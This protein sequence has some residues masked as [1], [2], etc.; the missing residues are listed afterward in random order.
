MHSPEWPAG[1]RLSEARPIEAYLR[2]L[3]SLEFTPE[4]KSAHAAIRESG[5]CSD[6]QLIDIWRQ[7]LPPP[8]TVE[9][10][11]TPL[12]FPVT[13]IRRIEFPTEKRAEAVL[14]L[15]EQYG[16]RPFLEGVIYQCIRSK[17]KGA[18][19]YYARRFVKQLAR[20]GHGNCAQVLQS[21]VKRR[22]LKGMTID[23]EKE[24]KWICPR[25][26]LFRMIR[27]PALTIEFD[28]LSEFVNWN[29]REDSWVSWFDT[30]LLKEG[31]AE[32][33]HYRESEN[34]IRSIKSG[35]RSKV[36]WGK[37]LTRFST[38]LV[39]MHQIAAIRFLV[40]E[41]SDSF[42]YLREL[43]SSWNAFL[44]SRDVQWPYIVASIEDRRVIRL[45]IWNRHK[46]V[47][48]FEMDALYDK[49]PSDI[50]AVLR[51]FNRIQIKERERKFCELAKGINDLFDSL[52]RY[53]S[54]P[55]GGRRGDGLA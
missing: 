49:H 35:L 9:R 40:S 12:Q 15:V 53:Q 51:K 22:F 38:V 25:C 8:K 43:R 41:Y 34:R 52:E 20:Y 44:R 21:G 18:W 47:D 46:L 32:L 28:Y 26:N 29:M 27:S 1:I 50:K 39:I 54:W 11:L 16:Y 33:V 31:L 48:D 14:E 4:K 23:V 24:L 3:R 2:W 42:R 37:E 17:E 45:A 19:E 36:V 30:E 10:F 13:T 5:T 7:V 55:T 6:F